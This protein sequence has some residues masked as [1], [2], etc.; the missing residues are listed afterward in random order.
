MAAGTDM[1]AAGRVP[2]SRRR[3]DNLEGLGPMAVAFPNADNP[4][5]QD[6]PMWALL[7]GH[8]EQ[9]PM[10]VAGL[11]EGSPDQLLPAAVLC[12]VDVNQ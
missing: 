9:M 12:L 6:E 2:W 11:P 8:W 4:L 1:P 5:D 10:Q 7:A 3:A